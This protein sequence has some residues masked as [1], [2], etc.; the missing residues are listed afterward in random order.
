MTFEEARALFPVLDR[1]AYLNA[2][3]F[4]PL[5]RP[6]SDAVAEQLRRDLE[7]GRSG[8]AYIDDAVAARSRVR[9]LVADLVGATSEHVS[10]TARRPTAAT[11]CS[12]GSASSRRTRS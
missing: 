7:R 9:D 2:G 12:R 6:T 5:A 1:L 8:R 10:L 11:S 4:G 3:T